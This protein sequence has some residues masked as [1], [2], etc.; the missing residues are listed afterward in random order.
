MKLKTKIDI[1][2][3]ELLHYI[4]DYEGALN[5]LTQYAKDHNAQNFIN[6]LNAQADMARY[7]EYWPNARRELEMKAENVESVIAM[8]DQQLAVLVADEA[9]FVQELKEARAMLRPVQEPK[10]EK[11]PS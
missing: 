4:E 3:G 5:C 7:L 6:A 2:N 9:D 10:S 8:T 1:M 11:Q